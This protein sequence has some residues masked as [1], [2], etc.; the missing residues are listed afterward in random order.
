VLTP[1]ELALTAASDG[2]D[3]PS[4]GNGQSGSSNSLAGGG[5]PPAL[6]SFGPDDPVPGEPL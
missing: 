1:K 6:P 2:K 3:M 5:S 4:S